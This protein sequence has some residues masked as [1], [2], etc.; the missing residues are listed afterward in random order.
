MSEIESTSVVGAPRRN[1]NIAIVASLLRALE[2][3]DIERALEHLAPTIVYQNYPLP[4][5]RGHAQVRRTLRLFARMANHFEVRLIHVAERDGIVLT[6]RTDVI[7]GPALD[8]EF[9]VC[10]TF[11]VRDGKIVLWR[12]RFDTAAFALQLLTSPVRSV[13]RAPRRG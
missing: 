8:L 12:D 13:L 7:R 4:P 5:D 6:E 2:S 11:E 10:G 1:E 3:F 9:W